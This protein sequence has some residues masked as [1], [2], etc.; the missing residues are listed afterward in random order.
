MSR[1]S[2]IVQCDGVKSERS[3]LQQLLNDLILRDLWDV[4][5][6]VVHTSQNVDLQTIVSTQFS[7]GATGNRYIYA[8]PYY[9]QTQ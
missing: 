4:R 1:Y 9:A 2:A 6:S 5:A 7:C 3:V 8:P